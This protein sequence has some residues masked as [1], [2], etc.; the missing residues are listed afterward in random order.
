MD[1]M[2]AKALAQ[3][4]MPI[5]LP[6]IIHMLLHY[7]GNLHNALTP[8]LVLTSTPSVSKSCSSKAFLAIV[9][10][11]S[12]M[13]SGISGGQ[14]TLAYIHKRLI[15]LD[16]TSGT[17]SFEWLLIIFFLLGSHLFSKCSLY[18]EEC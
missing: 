18:Y 16:K 12:S 13:S 5:W 10:A 15:Y 1:R 17:Y 3:E 8:L 4:H 14:S 7:F 11:S 9:I 2:A 6:L